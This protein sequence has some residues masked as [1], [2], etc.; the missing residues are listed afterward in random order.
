[1]DRAAGLDIAGRAFDVAKNL[2]ATRMSSL[3]PALLLFSLI[4]GAAVARTMVPLVAFYSR[5]TQSQLELAKHRGYGQSACKFYGIFPAPKLSV[6]AMAFC[7]CAF[8]FLVVAPATP[9]CPTELRAA[10]LGLALLFYHLYFSQLYCEAHVGAHV[11][12]LIPPA[13]IF[14]ALSPALDANAISSP[15][16]AQAAAFACWMMKVVITTAY[17]GAGVCKITHSLRSI[18]R[19]GSSWCTGSTLQ[20]FIFEAM[21][22]SNPSTQTSFGVPTPFSYYLQKMHL[23]HPRLLLL[24]ASYGAVA[25]ETLAPLLLLAPAHLASVPFAACGLGF[26]YGIALLQNSAWPQ[27]AWSP[28]SPPATIPA[29]CTRAHNLSVD[30][31]FLL[32]C[33]HPPLPVDFMSWW[34]P[35]YAFLLADPAAWSAGLLNAPLDDSL[36]FIQSAQATYAVAPLRTSLC[37]CYLAVHVIA[38]VVLRFFPSV[39]ILPLSSFPMFGTPQNLFDASLRKNLWLTEKAHATGTLKNYAFPFCRAHTVLASE[40]PALGF[41]YLLLSHGGDQLPRLLSNID[42]SPRLQAHLDRIIALGSQQAD[43]FATDPNAAASLLQEL[44]MAK[45]AFNAVPR[46]GTAPIVAGVPIDSSSTTTPA[47]PAGKASDTVRP[48]VLFD[49]VCLLCSAFVQFVLDHNKDESI[50]FA[51]LQGQ[52]G[53]QVLEKAGLP[54]D[55]STVVLVDEAG[56]HTRSTAALRVLMRCGLPYALLYYLFILVPRPL[57][58]LGYKGVAAVRYRVFGIDDGATCRRMTKATRDRFLDYAKAE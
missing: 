10:S 27:A 38:V 11:T 3:E 25:F 39:E 56:V 26:H 34:S 36:G 30:P 19:G 54:K 48:L 12:V 4:L 57:R 47:P 42:M 15:A 5:F 44:E 50:T 8:L 58:D 55:V 51:T 28:P 45:A 46:A 7:G 14:L 1:M 13:L 23:L 37:L 31:P 52:V 43:T 49:G 40:L 17:C 21:F 6:S 16:N 29:V 41:K 22:L 2:Q 9:M 35:A 18:A 32:H 53:A 20:S 24:P 33:V